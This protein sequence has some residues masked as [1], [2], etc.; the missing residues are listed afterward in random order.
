[1]SH[2]TTI[3]KDLLKLD[4]PLV[5]LF[6]LVKLPGDYHHARL[7]ML[8]YQDLT[9]FHFHESLLAPIRIHYGRRDGT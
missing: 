7:T 3:P 2:A 5:F 8:L 4:D 9:G 6:W 1:M